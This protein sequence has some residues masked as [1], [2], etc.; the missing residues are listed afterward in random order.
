MNTINLVLGDWSGDG[1]NQTE[2]ITIYS[3][4]T[5]EKLQEIYAKGWHKVGFDLTAVVCDE[6]EDNNISREAFDKLVQAGLTL[7]DLELTEYDMKAARASLADENG[8]ELNPYS[9]ARIY[10]FIA[11]LGDEDKE[12]EYE[13]AKNTSI[14]IGGYGLFFN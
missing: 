2:T 14:T 9:F 6:Y 4:Y 8:I 7:E 1:H 11:K 13:I 10:L 3:N 5:K 12:F